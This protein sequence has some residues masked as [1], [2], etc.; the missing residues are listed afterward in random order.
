[1]SSAEGRRARIHMRHSPEK[2]DELELDLPALDGEDDATSEEPAH[3]ALEVADDGGDAFDDSTGE[4]APHDDFVVEGAEGGWLV[5]AE[6]A[7]ALDVGPFDVAIEPEGKVLE[8]DDF[9]TR[10]GLEDLISSDEAFVADTGEEGPLAKDEELREEDLPALDADDDGDV[11]DDDLYDRGMLTADGE[12]R[13]DDRA[14]ARAAEVPAGSDEGDDS[15]VLVVP[16]DDPAQGARDK[17]WKRL[18]ESGRL[19]A[20]AFVPGGSIV[21]AL[22]TADRA[23][24]LVV[25]VQPDGEARIIAEIDPRATKE[26][27][28][29]EPCTVTF[30]RWDGARGC[31]FVGG[32][33]GVE[34]YRPG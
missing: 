21:V 31:L 8:D 5:D 23:R 17:T 2:N 11:A 7:G 3:D 30:I 4:G 24:A 15:G 27:D 9:D 16:G 20:A 19:M 28:D 32:N 25:R 33:F 12:L 29:G 13:W 18:D 22:G 34:A 14:W 1:M 26:D 6:M 10:G